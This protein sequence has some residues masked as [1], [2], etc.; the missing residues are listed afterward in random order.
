M[1]TVYVVC[2]I[3]HCTEFHAT[4]NNMLDI[5]TTFIQ[6]PLCTIFAL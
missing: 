3:E 1:F 2:E 5:V 6:E 4:S